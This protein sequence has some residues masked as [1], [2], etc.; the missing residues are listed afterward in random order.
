[1]QAR[2]AAALASLDWP[3]N[4]LESDKV[5]H[6][7]TLPRNRSSLQRGK[8]LPCDGSSDDTVLWGGKIARC[9]RESTVDPKA[10]A[11]TKPAQKSVQRNRNPPECFVAVSRRLS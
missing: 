8:R 9:G 4:T 2:D 7:A 11:I 10:L 1:M 6:T 3:P 5:I